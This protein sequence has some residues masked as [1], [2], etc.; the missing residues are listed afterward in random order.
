MT[1]LAPIGVASWSAVVEHS[2]LSDDD[3]FDVEAYLGKRG[4]KYFSRGTKLWLA[5]CAGLDG[6]DAGEGAG[7]DLTGIAVGTNFGAHQTLREMHDVVLQSGPLALSPSFAPNFCVN[8]I[9]GQAAIRYGARRFNL[10]ITTPATAGLDAIAIAARELAA[11]RCKSVLAG[12]AEEAIPVAPRHREGAVALLLTGDEAAGIEAR[13]SGF[14][15]AR[16]PEAALPTIQWRSHFAAMLAATGQLGAQAIP[17]MLFADPARPPS[18]VT[19]MLAAAGLAIASVDARTVPAV[20]ATLEPVMAL[21]D[22][23]K[24]VGNSGASMLFC[25]VGPAGAL[26]LIRIDPA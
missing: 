10:T 6:L 13:L 5:A 15:E 9:A 2:M 8:L 18:Q 19:N 26:R 22:T 21:L 17:L 11:G 16:L 7:G 14:G 12:A 24:A 25:Y 3:W 20:H 1:A 4:H 23:V